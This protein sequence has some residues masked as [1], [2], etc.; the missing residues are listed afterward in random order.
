MC[1]NPICK[2]EAV[3]PIACRFC[4]CGKYCCKECRDL[5][6]ERH[7]CPNCQFELPDARTCIARPY[8]G[9]DVF[10]S[11]P[12]EDKQ[13]L[14]AVF[15]GTYIDEAGNFMQRESHPFI[16]GE[17]ISGIEKLAYTTGKAPSDRMLQKKAYVLTVRGND[18]SEIFSAACA[19]PRD[20]IFK[21]NKA[22]PKA[23]E[24]AGGGNVLKSFFKGKTTARTREPDNVV[25]NPDVKLLEEETVRIPIR[26]KLSVEVSGAPNAWIST[27]Y[28]LTPKK[29]S[30]TGKEKGII[31]RFKEQASTM[32]SNAMKNVYKVKFAKDDGKTYMYGLEN[33]YAL[34]QQDLM[35]ISL[36]LI[37]LIEGGNVG[38]ARLVDIELS[39]PEYM[40]FEEA[41]PALAMPPM[42]SGCINFDPRNIEDVCA[43][44]M[45]QEELIASNVLQENAH[46]AA[47]RDYYRKFNENEEHPFTNEARV[48]WGIAVD[49]VITQRT[50]NAMRRKKKGKQMMWK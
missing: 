19:V 18:G 34:Y 9:E 30:V 2:G 46:T 45:L 11:D 41:K 49:K 40:L 26:G 7:D 38:D 29:T 35:G 16:E 32:L 6:H 43:L 15:A 39:V 27:I 8:M 37:V 33:L 17:A 4:G 14:N 3:S 23:R 44:V 25:F 36:K 5:D 22:N 50:Q 20:F 1:D 24:L 48:G 47:L 12:D 31:G 42:S 28:Q 13:L 10:R 21:E